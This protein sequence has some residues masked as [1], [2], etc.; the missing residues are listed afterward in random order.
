MHCNYNDHSAPDLTIKNAIRQANRIDLETLAFT[1]HVRKNSEWVPKYLRELEFY[2]NN[3]TIRIVHGFEAKILEDGSIDCPERYSKDYFLIASFHTKYNSKKIWVN[4]LKKA[5]ENPDVNVIGHIA[6]ECSFALDRTEVDELASLMVKNKKI[7]ELNAKY[8]RPP[9]DWVVILKKKGV[10][11]HL[12]S[13]AHSLEEIGRY[14]K[15]SD[16]ILLADSS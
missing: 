16:L 1:E 13:D 11:L 7:V 6:P 9:N 3:S 14:Q 5:I 4:A 15:I 12:G 10:T 8:H 2:D